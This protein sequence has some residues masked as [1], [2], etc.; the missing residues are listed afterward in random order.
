MLAGAPD[1][2]A[3]IDANAGTAWTYRALA[4]EV[5]AAAQRLMAAAGAGPAFLFA[6]NDLA[7]VIELLAALTAGVPIAVGR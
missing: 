1:A 7:T 5:G 3:V 4:A 6:R 2:I